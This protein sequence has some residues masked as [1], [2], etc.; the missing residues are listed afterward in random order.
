MPKPA[1]ILILCCCLFLIFCIYINKTHLQK[2]FIINKNKPVTDLGGDRDEYGCIPS[3]GYNWCE[4]KNKCVR[5][6]EEEC[7]VLE[8]FYSD[9]NQYEKLI[10]Q[11]TESIRKLKN[12]IAKSNL[13]LENIEKK[14]KEMH[15]KVKEGEKQAAKVRQKSNSTYLKKK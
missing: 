7:D 9:N 13:R 2:I 12:Q 11:N 5:L 6:W 3:A 8:G 15:N 10:Q 1:Y 14:Q 4:S